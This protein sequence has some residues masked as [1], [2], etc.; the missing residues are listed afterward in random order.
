M[1]DSKTYNGHANYATWKVN[2]EIVGPAK[3][4]LIGMCADSIKE[5][6][7]QLIEESS[8]G[9]GQDFA[10]AFLDDVSWECIEETVN[11]N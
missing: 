7:Q 4:D 11:E 5:Y 9:V 2:L 3:N 10:L 8:I 6:C 1:R